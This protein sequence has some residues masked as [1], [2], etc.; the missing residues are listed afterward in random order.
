MAERPKLKDSEEIL[1]SIG[2]RTR[3]P[4]ITPPEPED[5]PAKQPAVEPLVASA[6]DAPPAPSGRRGGR[7]RTSAQTSPQEQEDLNPLDFGK[8]RLTSQPPARAE[9]PPEEEPRPRG[10]RASARP[11]AQSG[12]IAAQIDA[13]AR[14]EPAAAR[15]RGRPPKQKAELQPTAPARPEIKEYQFADFG[16]AA[17]A[18]APEAAQAPSAE[19]DETPAPRKRG[20]PRKSLPAE[21]PAGPASPQDRKEARE[22]SFPSLEELEAKEAASPP[23]KQPQLPEDL[24]PDEEKRREN[25]LKRLSSQFDEEFSQRFHNQSA[26]EKTAKQHAAWFDLTPKQAVSGSPLL[27]NEELEANQEADLF[28]RQFEEQAREEEVVQ[29]ES[30]KDTLAEKFMRERERYLKELGIDEEEEPEPYRG[31]EPPEADF[32]N[33]F[34]AGPEAEAPPRRR[35]LDLQ[36]QPEM[37]RQDGDREPLPPMT[38]GPGGA[39]R[40]QRD[41]GEDLPYIPAQ[42]TPA[43]SKQTR[44][45]AR[46]AGPAFSP[47]QKP[48]KKTSEDLLMELAAINSFKGVQAMLPENQRQAAPAPQKPLKLHFA[49]PGEELA[50][51]EYEE[52][53][54]KK[55]KKERPLEKEKGHMGAPFKVN[56]VVALSAA[57][58]LLV[59]AL[60]AWPLAD[61]LR[62]DDGQLPAGDAAARM[63][64]DAEDI[65]NV[66][67]D[68]LYDT[69]QIANN[70]VVKKANVTLRNME[71]QGRLQI[72]D[73]ASTGTVTLED[74]NVKGE[75]YVGNTSVDVL[76]LNN[77]TTDNIVINN[78]KS[79]VKLQVAGNTSIISMEVKSPASIQQE[80]LGEGAAGIASMIMNRVDAAAD[81]DVELAGMQLRTVAAEGGCVVALQSSRID[82]LT[83][84]GNLSLSGEGSVISVASSPTTPGEKVNLSLKGVPIASLS[85]MGE[86]DAVVDTRVDMIATSSPLDLRGNGTVGTLMLNKGMYTSRIP[87]NLNGALVQSLICDTQARVNSTGDAKVNSL[88]AN[89]SVYALGNK[90]NQLYVNAD[91]VI[92]ENEPDK[93]SVRPG[94]R[95]ASTVA[96]NP[97]LD[98]DLPASENLL[99]TD[100]SGDAVATTCNHPRE[101]GGF[102]RGDGSR[103]NPFE[104]STAAQ[105]AHVSAHL[106]SHYV[107]TADIDI[108]DDS[109]FI[110]GFTPIASGGSPFTGSYNGGG[111]TVT[112]LR[113][114]GSGQNIGL[115]AEN[116][117]TIK[118]VRV[119]AGDVKSSG[120]G[121]SYVG[122]VVGF[123]YQG[124]VVEACSNGAKV[125]ATGTGY[126]GGV[127]GYNFGGKVRDSYNYAKI[128]GTANVGGVVGVNAESA[129]VVGCYN[130]GTIDA[131]SEAGAVVGSNQNAA[132]ANCYFLEDTAEK[133]IGRGSGN[134]MV[135]TS[136]EISAP[137]MALDL[138]AGNDEST[139]SIP[140][141]GS[142]TYPVHTVTEAVAEP[143]EE[144][145]IPDMPQE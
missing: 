72:D 107:Q 32:D 5:L 126:A 20:R 85:L 46:P 52:P 110:S 63:S 16:E 34:A 83:G 137:Q 58:A 124:G 29:A 19:A 60:A 132:I 134:V 3:Q 108:A 54:K 51:D 135:K 79:R 14:E 101:S 30:F 90:I 116:T 9:E 15:K 61:W 97:N 42:E 112:N 143:V 53:Q 70:V 82:S 103:E 78:P 105:L 144:E 141:S 104:A 75:I 87:V 123:N 113:I 4:R 33:R 73:I 81:L 56:R 69:V 74:L 2:K 59:L 38:Y 129:S 13:A 23:P 47:G 28:L 77:V 37:H 96:D 119:L 22:Y 139:W 98:Y 36:I 130:V 80:R 114:T 17:L 26:A 136:D 24:A 31:F 100:T 40:V 92:Y 111:H 128:T 102:V 95:P 39:A 11:T 27:P 142:Y 62:P 120:G 25:F 118:N 117:G 50:E 41:S 7:P 93:I 140:L 35:R 48:G 55:A 10:R 65:L 106:S 122:G 71:V 145:P 133:G 66:Y 99:P 44:A 45:G 49:P 21:K 125:T 94:M 84:R 43:A 1:T 138:A 88:T 12:D 109:A 18:E 64:P 121:R 8:Y 127:V 6:L 67:E 89:E 115:F 131:A 76:R 86:T 57:A 91:G 68:H